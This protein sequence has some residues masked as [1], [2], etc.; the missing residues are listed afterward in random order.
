[1]AD[2]WRAV[3]SLANMVGETSAHELGHTLG[4]A[5]PHLGVNF[6]HNSGDGPGCLMDSGGNRP[7][8][9]RVAAEGFAETEFC[10]EAEGYLDRIL[11]R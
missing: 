10:A 11:P 2:V 5:N 9:E 8:G 6:T 1:V 3:Q 4:L 7:V